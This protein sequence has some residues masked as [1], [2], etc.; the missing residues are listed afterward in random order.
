MNLLAAEPVA[1]PKPLRRKLCV[2]EIA[3]LKRVLL[4]RLKKALSYNPVT[5]EFRWLI[6]PARNV[7]AGSVAGFIAFWPLVA[8]VALWGM[9]TSSKLWAMASSIWQ[10]RER[11]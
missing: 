10:E 1:A 2:V 4:E 3:D 11:L 6:S 8:T 9:A 5:G 7:R